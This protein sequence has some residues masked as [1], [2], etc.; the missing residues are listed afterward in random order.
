MLVRVHDNAE[1]RLYSHIV[2]LEALF[3]VDAGDE[4]EDPW[5]AEQRTVRTAAGHMQ[6]PPGEPRGTHD[7]GAADI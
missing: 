7:L 3:G 1:C 4:E 2:S 6:C 5:A